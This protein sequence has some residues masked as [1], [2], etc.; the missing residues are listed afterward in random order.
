MET[1]QDLKEQEEICICCRDT[2]VEDSN[3]Y[4]ECTECDE[5]YGTD[6][7]KCKGS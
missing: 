6:K 5:N 4:M 7:C 2:L 1:K 3:G